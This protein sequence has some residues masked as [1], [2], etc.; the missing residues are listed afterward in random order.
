MA[1]TQV[2]GG[3]IL[4]STTLTTPIVATTMG[5]GGATP[6]ASGSGITF[7]ATQSAS[8]DANTLD[9][10]EEGTYTATMTCSTS[11]TITLN[12]SFRTLSYTKIGRQV[13]V[14]GT[15]NVDSVSSPTGVVWI[16]LPFTTGA[17]DPYQSAAIT[18]WNGL[19]SSKAANSSWTYI[20]NNFSRISVY[21][22]TVNSVGSSN[23]AQYVVSGADVR[24][25]A[26]YFV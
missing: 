4:P 18:S 1:L 17:T 6:A 12:T 5:V 24:V 11:G 22:G 8:S 3:M 19:G 26:S 9:D 23:F 2:Q 21:D 7:P 14:T 25:S 10:Y 13:T 15:L 16:S 20:P